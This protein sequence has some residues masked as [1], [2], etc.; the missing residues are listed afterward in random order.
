VEEDGVEGTMGEEEDGVEGTMGVEED[1][2]A[3]T[4]GVEED[5]VEGTMGEEKDGVEE[6]M[7]E[8]ETMEDGVL[9]TSAVVVVEAEEEGVEAASFTWDFAPT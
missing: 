9:L 4:M 3:G 1:G 8:E 5:G 2:V 6:T 7:G